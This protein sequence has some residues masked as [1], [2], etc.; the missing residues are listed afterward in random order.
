MRATGSRPDITSL[1]VV[2]L[3]NNI[4]GNEIADLRFLEAYASWTEICYCPLSTPKRIIS[5][6]MKDQWCKRWVR[7]TALAKTIWSNID[8]GLKLPTTDK[9][10][11]CDK[12]MEDVDGYQYWYNRPSLTRLRK[13]K[14][15]WLFPIAPISVNVSIT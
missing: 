14:N 4:E 12:R 2:P 1:W 10:Y 11:D 3:D 9:F 13:E 6:A 5:N 8:K 15:G 7:S